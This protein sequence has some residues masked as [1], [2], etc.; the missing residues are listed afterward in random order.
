MMMTFWVSFNDNLAGV[1]ED[2]HALSLPRRI[3]T[4]A[5]GA[6]KGLPPYIAPWMLPSGAPATR[7][8]SAGAVPQS[9]LADPNPEDDDGDKKGRS[10]VGR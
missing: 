3:G 9:D 5:G 10:D 2:T 8:A 4:A 7:P 1:L 6:R